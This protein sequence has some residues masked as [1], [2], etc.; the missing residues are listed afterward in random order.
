MD[1][2]ITCHQSVEQAEQTRRDIE[3]LGRRCAVIRVD[4]AESDS[5]DRV[6]DGFSARFDRLDALVNNASCFSASPLSGLRAE[7]FDYHLA[8]NARAPLMLTRRFAA[9]LGAQYQPSD[10]DSAGRVVNLTDTCVEG[11]PMRGYAAYCASKA[12]LAQITRSLAVELAPRVTVNAVAPGVV[13]WP[14]D[15]DPTTK[16]RYIA[17]VPLGRAGR[18]SDAAAAVLCLVRDAPYCT[19]QV[20]RLDGGRALR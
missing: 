17:R 6:F 14:P 12:A 2:A 9:M 1:V 4:L 16:D 11:V 20:I 18:P 19:G 10:L 7:D 13:D 8:I 15:T 5:A 3:S